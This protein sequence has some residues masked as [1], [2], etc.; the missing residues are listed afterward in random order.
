AHVLAACFMFA[1]VRE[2]GMGRFA[3]FLAGI[4]FSLGGFVS[5]MTWPHM[6]E[7][8]M[9]LPLIFLFLL[10]GFR[11]FDMR[12]AIVNASAGGLMLGMAVVAGGLHII[13]LQAIAVAAAG[14]FYA[15]GVPEEKLLPRRGIERW[16]RTLVVVAVIGVVG[17]AIGAVQLAASMEFSPL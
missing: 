16:K 17:V 8:A 14:V 15:A 6:L 13:W 5:K 4:C 9:W 1:L 12:S 7:S 3:A 2:L 11:A 10:R